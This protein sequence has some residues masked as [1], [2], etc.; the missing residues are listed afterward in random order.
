MRPMSGVGLLGAVVLMAVPLWSGATIATAAAATPS[1]SPQASPAGIAGL[2]ARLTPGAVEPLRPSARQGG[3][4]TPA[5]A[6]FPCLS[7]PNPSIT[8][9]QCYSVQQLRTAYDI[10]PLLNSGITGKGQTIVII[11]LSSLPT[12]RSDVHAFD[13]VWGL[14]DPE[15]TI[16]APSG[17]PQFIDEPSA[18][19]AEE[20][21]IAHAIAPDAAINVVQ[22]PALTDS[23]T[24]LEKQFYEWLKPLRYAIDRRLGNVIV[25]DWGIAGESC[26]DG[27]FFRYQHALLQE[28]RARH[29][30]VAAQSGFFGA[31]SFSCPSPAAPAPAVSP[32]T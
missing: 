18:F 24:T 3:P 32:V 23:D 5:S 16:I 13:Q 17:A 30:T 27:A 15:L 6:D 12:L 4:A 8:N 11:A 29:V 20:V 2:L 31:G 19:A 26:F 1:P 10:T 28:A 7:N 25:D 21:E 14:S 22:S 9:A